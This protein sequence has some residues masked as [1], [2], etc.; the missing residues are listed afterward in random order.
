MRATAFETCVP[1]APITALPVSLMQTPSRSS[2][3]LTLALA[4][5]AAFA[6]LAPFYLIAAH[7]MQDA[8]LFL[9]RSGT[10]LL[11]GLALVLWAVLFGWP[12]MKRLGLI[13]TRRQIR[14]TSAD[15]VVREQGLF[16]DRVWSQPLS[17]YRGLA[18]HVRSSMSGTRHEVLLVHPDPA[19]SLLLRAADRIGQDEIDQMAVLTGCREIAPQVFY[20]RSVARGAHPYDASATGLI[21]AK[22]A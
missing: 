8:S 11:L 5:P 1:C 19:K 6:A 15:V 9:E 12:I 7:A 14:L 20:R 13:G 22:L 4:F 16:A 18:H 17:A 21:S 2:P 3:F 10:S